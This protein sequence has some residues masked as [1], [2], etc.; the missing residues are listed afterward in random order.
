MIP[1]THADSDSVITE[2]PAKYQHALRCED[3]AKRCRC[4]K[5]TAE[6]GYIPAMCD[7]GLMCQH[8]IATITFPVLTTIRI[9]G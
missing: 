4:L 3:A 6:A 9:P 5:E 2:L 7:Y 8:C 1:K